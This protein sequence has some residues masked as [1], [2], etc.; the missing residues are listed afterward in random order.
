MRQH[1]RIGMFKQA[2]FKRNLDAAKNQLS[3]LDEPM[4]VKPRA[5]VRVGG[6]RLPPVFR[7]GQL[8]I[9]RA[10]FGK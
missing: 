6:E 3:P 9:R 2:L 4:R 8:L 5:K 7:G 10:S 1:V